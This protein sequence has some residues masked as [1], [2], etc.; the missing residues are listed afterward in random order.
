[1]LDQGDLKESCERMFEFGYKSGAIL[2]TD[3]VQNFFLGLAVF[4]LYREYSDFIWAERGKECIKKVKVWAEQGSSWNFKQKLKMLEAEESYCLG[5]F[6]DAKISYQDAISAARLH[7]HLLDEALAFELAA[8]FY[9]QIGDVS[10]SLKHY[11]KA[12]ETYCK[13]GADG[14]ADKLFSFI[15]DKFASHLVGCNIDC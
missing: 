5:D 15:K 6:D 4:R 11:T 10:T 7:K 14:K 12:H 1:M 3:S 8:H 2:Y 9:F 13:Y